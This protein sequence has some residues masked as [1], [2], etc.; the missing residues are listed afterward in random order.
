MHSVSFLSL[1]DPD[2]SIDYKPPYFATIPVKNGLG[3]RKQVPLI[4]DT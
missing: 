3:T 4:L 2:L 1:N